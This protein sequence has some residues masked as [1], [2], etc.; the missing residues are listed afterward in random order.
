M[1]RAAKY[2]LIAVLATALI[3]AGIWGAYWLVGATDGA[4]WL[5]DA[6]SRHTPLTISARTIEGNCS[7]VCNWGR[8]HGPGAGRGGNQSLDFRWARSASFRE[9]LPRKS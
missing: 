3:G 5:M 4:R 8:S 2:G 9:G 6:L 7:T 1:K